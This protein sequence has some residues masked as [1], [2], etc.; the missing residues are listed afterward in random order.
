[1]VKTISVILLTLLLSIPTYGSCSK[2]VQY[3]K[4]GEP[5]QCTGYLFSP[6]QEFKVRVTTERE[7]IL[8]NMIEKH[9]E[10]NSIL[11]KRLDNS[12]D[13]NDYLSKELREEK[14][15]SFWVNTL[16]F[17]LG[18]VLTGIIATNVNE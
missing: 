7:E 8:K 3:L 10:I 2:P 4:I 15:N 6:E 16:Y 9:V 14:R 17:T 1:M 18:A 5:A 13:Y 12:I 11:E